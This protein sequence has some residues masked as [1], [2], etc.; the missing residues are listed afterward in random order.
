MRYIFFISILTC[1]MCPFA[2]ANDD[3]S[4]LYIGAHFGGA[5]LDNTIIDSDGYSNHPKGYEFDY[6]DSGIIGG[7]LGGY[8]WRF[9]NWVTGVEAD[10]SFGEIRA[11]SNEFDTSQYDELVESIH[12]WSSTLRGRIGYAFGDYLPYI[13][14]GLAVA[15]ITNKLTDDDAGRIDP[16]DSFSSTGTQI[17][18]VLGAGAEMKMTEALGFRLEGLYADYGRVDNEIRNKLAS[19]GQRNTMTTIR[20]ALVYTF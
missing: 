17:G 16:L 20:A 3:F 7:F 18:W 8:N 1:L 14:G 6:S 4:G 10:V 9:N 5:Q 12:N 11:S 13:T 15:N 19:F 2:F